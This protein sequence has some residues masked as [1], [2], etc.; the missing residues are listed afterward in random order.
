M[1]TSIKIAMLIWCLVVGR[2]YAVDLS[3]MVVYNSDFSRVN[4]PSLFI[5]NQINYSNQVSINSN[6]TTRYVLVHHQELNLPNS[7]TVSSGFRDS[8]VISPDLLALRNQYRPDLVVYLTRSS[9]SLCGI[10][11]FPEYTLNV[12]GGTYTTEREMAAKGVSVVGWDC[13][14]DVFPHEIGHNLGGG[15]GPVDIN[16]EYLG[17]LISDDIHDHPGQPI[18]SSRGHGVRDIFRTIMAYSDVFGNAPR[19]AF[20]SN[21]A[22]NYNGLPTGTGSR[23]NSNGMDLIATKHVQYYS[24]CFPATLKTVANPRGS[25]VVFTCGGYCTKY[26][27]VYEG[28]FLVNKCVEYLP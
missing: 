5:Q 11:L 3:V 21:P 14:V 12:R 1:K 23:N 20:H 7:S 25:S 26:E 24:S 22:I 10:S 18:A 13:G 16:R 6:M 8:L 4:N 27:K 19:L 28:R 17:G 9:S 2:S 15:H